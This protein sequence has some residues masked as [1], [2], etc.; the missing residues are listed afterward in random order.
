M[1]APHPRPGV[2]FVDV[3]A[4]DPAVLLT[5]SWQCY[6]APLAEYALHAM[7]SHEWRGQI[8]WEECGS[9]GPGSAAGLWHAQVGVAGWGAVGQRVAAVAGALGASVRVLSR[10]AK[11]DTGSGITH[12]TRLPD[13]LDV[14][15]L[16]I[17]LPLTP[18]THHLFDRT[19]L[20]NARPG[21]HL[22]QCFAGA[23]H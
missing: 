15:H 11:Q 20:A 2:D 12:T 23:N 1:G 19:A 13:V 4:W 9:A 22:S 10:I 8:R 17:A 6:A 3:A 5:R 18:T 16:V 14:D 21:M 7:L